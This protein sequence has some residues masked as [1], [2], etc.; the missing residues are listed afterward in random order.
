VCRLLKTD[1][2]TR[3]AKLKFQS[4]A[5]FIESEYDN[6]IETPLADRETHE[7]VKRV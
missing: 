4:S 2:T 1:V 7:H 6:T 5:D 3:N